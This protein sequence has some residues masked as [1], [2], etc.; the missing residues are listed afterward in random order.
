[1]H[2]QSA[3]QLDFPVVYH[4]VSSDQLRADS[5]RLDQ[6]MVI[7]LVSGGVSEGLLG[8]A[9]RLVGADGRGS[10]GQGG[11]ATSELCLKS[12]SPVLWGKQSASLE[13]VSMAA[14]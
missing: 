9:V 3:L 8:I 12:N 6:M 11:A 5:V 14:C 1:M 2:R 10:T 13:V 7:S 4:Q